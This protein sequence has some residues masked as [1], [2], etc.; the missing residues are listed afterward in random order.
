MK[1]F[2]I[3]I[4]DRKAT[5]IAGD[6]SYVFPEYE[7]GKQENLII[8]LFEDCNPSIIIHNDVYSFKF[9]SINKILLH[10]NGSFVDSVAVEDIDQ[11]Y[12][13]LELIK[14]MGFEGYIKYCNT[15]VI[16]PQLPDFSIVHSY[17]DLVKLFRIKQENG[18]YDCWRF[19]YK[20]DD[21]HMQSDWYDTWYDQHDKRKEVIINFFEVVI[22]R[23]PLVA[24]P[25]SFIMG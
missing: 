24:V 20:I 22:L 23:R 10:R 6:K 25:P 9:V 2:E 17:E 7:I 14:Q 13:I 15:V 19:H 16:P 5:I 21:Y 11:L 1:R 18:E 3:I 8:R 4:K 12:K